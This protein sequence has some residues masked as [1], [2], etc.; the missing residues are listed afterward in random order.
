[1]ITIDAIRAG[2]EYPPIREAVRLN[3]I[4]QNKS[5][6]NG[7][8]SV[9]GI[10]NRADQSTVSTNL[11]RRV[12]TFFPDFLFSEDLEITTGNARFD[13]VIE[14]MKESLVEAL[15]LRQH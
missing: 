15:I 13:S 2:K 8:Y 14:T 9:L 10:M 12:A 11:F 4:Y 6:Y 5:L 1:M 7:D 3:R